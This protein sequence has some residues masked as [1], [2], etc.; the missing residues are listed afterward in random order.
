MRGVACDKAGARFARATGTATN[1]AV[2]VTIPAVADQQHVIDWVHSSFDSTVSSNIAVTIASAGTTIFKSYVRPTGTALTPQQFRMGQGLE[3]G[4]N[5]EVVVTLGASGGTLTG[6][7]NV[8]F[9]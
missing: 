1:E 2:T 6:E 3:C 8:G 7:L 4:I 9:R 5:K